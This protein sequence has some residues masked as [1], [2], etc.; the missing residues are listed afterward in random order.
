MKKIKL[1]KEPSVIKNFFRHLFVGVNGVELELGGKIFC[2]IIPAF[3]LSASERE[4][5]LKKRWELIR[6]AQQRTKNI[7]ANVL[8][9]KIR[10]AIQQVRGK[11]G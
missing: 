9:K 4:G 7:P 2:Q 6:L 11:R 5:L 3:S 8:A 10:Q 1:D